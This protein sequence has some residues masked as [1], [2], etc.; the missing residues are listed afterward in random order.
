MF[1]ICRPISAFKLLSLYVLTTQNHT[2]HTPAPVTSSPQQ[3]C[4]PPAGGQFNDLSRSNN[5]K[6][7]MLTRSS[8][9]AN[10][11]NRSCLYLPNK[12]TTFDSLVHNVL[13]F[14]VL[15]QAPYLKTKLTFSF[16]NQQFFSGHKRM[17]FWMKETFILFIQWI[18]RV[19]QVHL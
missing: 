13:G 7:L 19:M 17:K 12:P 11:H 16:D 9:V 14:F 6:M 3:G 18:L 15:Q 5:W 2:K 8:N 1:T 4:Q 10:P